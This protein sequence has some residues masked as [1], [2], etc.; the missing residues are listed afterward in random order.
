MGTVAESAFTLE[1][2]NEAVEHRAWNGIFPGDLE[3]AYSAHL[4]QRNKADFGRDF[5]RAILIY[6]AFLVVDYLVL[7]E[8]AE[9]SAFLH[10]CVITPAMIFLSRVYVKAKTLRIQELAWSFNTILVFSQILFI[11]WIAHNEARS[12]YLALV[13][14]VVIFYNIERPVS[15]RLAQRVNILMLFGFVGAVATTAIPLDVVVIGMLVLLTT[16]YT[17][18]RANWRLERDLRFS[19]LRLLQDEARLKLAQK[20]AFIDP[21]TGLHNRRFLGEFIAAKLG[22]ETVMG[23]IIAD[24]DHFKF[25][26]DN[27]GHQAG[28]KCL[29]R[30]ASTI[31][32]Q[33][34]GTSDSVI[35]YGGEEFLILLPGADLAKTLATAER[36]RAA[37]E[38]LAIARD[39]TETEGI[40]TAS[41]GVASGVFHA[42]HFAELLKRAD[43]ALY[44]AK[45]AGRNR[46]Y[47]PLTEVGS[48]AERVVSGGA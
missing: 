25:Y 17:T 6:N 37:V 3:R 23:V 1:R 8:V 29:C 34:T 16:I 15:F 20:D 19:F 46:V 7:P 5:W 48:S 31:A 21:L 40:V 39:A 28:D 22:V 35:R 41:F 10:F 38:A 30:V 42:E 33:M 43:N 13:L 4:L 24:I 11:V 45:N 27:Y 18:M 47:P 36:L 2:L 44:A 14:L 32:L 9:I 26:N 12:H